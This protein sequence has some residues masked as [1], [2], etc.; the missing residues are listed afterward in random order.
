MHQRNTNNSIIN[1][2]GQYANRQNAHVPFQNNKLINNNVHVVNTLNR[3]LH[4]KP[5]SSLGRGGKTTNIIEELL[6]PINVYTS[7][8]TQG[9]IKQKYEERRQMKEDALAG[10]MEYKI[11]NVPYKNIIKDKVITKKIEDVT[12]EDIIVHRVVKEVDSDILKFKND[13]DTKTNE[14]REI[15]DEIKLEYSTANYNKHK[16]KYIY[17]KNFIRNL[18]YESSDVKQDY[19]EFYKKKQEEQEKCIE[20]CDEII[21][22]LVDDGYIDTNELPFNN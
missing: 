15:D 9:E 13:L 16:K 5:A 1:N 6:R 4:P 2:F 20:L 21:K 10:K 19:I 17:N 3:T 11:T 18:A 8:D 14:R 12:P 22:K 7:G